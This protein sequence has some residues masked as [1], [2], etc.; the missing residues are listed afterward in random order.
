MEQTGV[1][2]LARAPVR[3]IPHRCL[4]VRHHLAGCAA[5][6]EACPRGAV[7]LAPGP[8]VDAGRCNGCGVCAAVC[9]TEALELR[10][11]EVSAVVAAAEGATMEVACA[12]A[13]GRRALQ[14]PCLG[15]LDAGTLLALAAEHERILLDRGP[16][17]ACP[18]AAGLRTAEGAVAVANTLLMGY[19]GEPRIE[20]SASRPYVAGTAMS[21]RDLFGFLRRKAR[22]RLE[23]DPEPPSGPVARGKAMRGELRPARR[24]QLVQEVAR[25]AAAGQGVAPE[26]AG[27]TPLPFYAVTI[28]ERCDNCGMCLT[29]C[30]TAALR[31]E[32][33]G[34]S[35][36]YT[37]TGDYCIGCGL[38]VAVCPREAVQ[39]ERV[40]EPRL[41]PPVAVLRR[42][43]RH[44]RDCGQTFAGA[45]GELRCRDCAKKVTLDHA[46][47]RGLF[48]LGQ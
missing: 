34:G 35:L 9:P 37:F 16:C 43:T 29:F 7:A 14:V 15:F 24:T 20:F 26:V 40:A 32:H 17:L 33:G 38:C 27:Q 3:S 22:E 4:R 48:G 30:P 21:R 8:V 12:H 13:G 45:P 42:E 11:P 10:G 2:S 41:G 25:L 44:C 19:G 1:T 5:C 47:R 28:D 39:M 6:S 18:E 46:I 36:A 31:A 23:V